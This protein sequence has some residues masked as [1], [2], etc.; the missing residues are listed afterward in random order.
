[1]LM[2][3]LTL[4]PARMGDYD[5]AL[6]LYLESVKPLLLA[7]GRWDEER[8]L[9]RFA[10]GFKLE[11]IK[12]L[13]RAGGDIGW[14]QVSENEEEMHL[15]Q[16]HLVE[17]ARNQ[18]IGTHLIRKLQDRARAAD[19]PLALN[20]IQGNPAKALYERLGFRSDGGD[21]EKIRMLWRV[22][23]ADAVA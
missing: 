16:L 15:D 17:G 19:K 9:S 4:R 23:P 11:Q 20:V 18:K 1:M 5:F 10:E 8:I 21:E 13:R 2:P 6:A 14:M 7:L 22:E 12:V 3:E